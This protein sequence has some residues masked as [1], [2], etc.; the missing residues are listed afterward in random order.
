MPRLAF[1]GEGD[2]IVYGENFGGVTVDIAGAMRGHEETLKDQ[3][4]E[5]AILP[6][7]DMNHTKAMQP[8]AVLP[9]I[10]PWLTARLLS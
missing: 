9:L 8:S 3:G 4:W 2:T 1:A 5:I 7:D 10:K 6:G